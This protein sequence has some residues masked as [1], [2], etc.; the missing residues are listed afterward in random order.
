MYS[1]SLCKITVASPLGSNTID[2][3]IKDRKELNFS[4]VALISTQVW[5]ILSRKAETKQK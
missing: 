4:Q 3:S 5:Q 2:D 1:F